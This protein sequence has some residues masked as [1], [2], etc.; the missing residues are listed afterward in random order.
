MSS[1]SLQY[2]KGEVID[3]IEDRIEYL[4]NAIRMTEAYIRYCQTPAIM[5]LYES[6]LDYCKAQL[7]ESRTALEFANA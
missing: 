4:L 1:K 7:I 2:S 3:D 5:K 6:Q